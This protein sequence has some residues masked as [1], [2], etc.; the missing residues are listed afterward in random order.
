MHTDFAGSTAYEN[1]GRIDLFPKAFKNVE[2]LLRTVIHEKAHVKQ[3]TKYGKDYTQSNIEFMERTA[4]RFENLF[5]NIASK[6]RGS[7]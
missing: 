4:V 6:R 2:Q 1:V 3:L 5:Y 7:K